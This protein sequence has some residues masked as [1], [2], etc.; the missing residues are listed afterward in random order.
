MEFFT[1]DGLTHV[2]IPHPWVGYVTHGGHPV[3]WPA[4][5]GG[6]R[7]ECPPDSAPT[8]SS[9]PGSP[10]LAADCPGCPTLSKYG[11]F[12]SLLFT[13][14]YVTFDGPRLPLSPATSRL[15]ACSFDFSPPQIQHL[16][17]LPVYSHGTRGRVLSPPSPSPTLI[18]TRPPL[19]L[20]IHPTKYAIEST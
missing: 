1:F 18:P 8:L 20:A 11:G 9:R 13:L 17:F 5:H 4:L 15:F 19:P 16:L 10:G 14:S 7:S 2:V 6:T 3:T 12:S